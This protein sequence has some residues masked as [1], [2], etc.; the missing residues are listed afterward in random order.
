MAELALLKPG[1]KVFYY[2]GVRTFPATVVDE[3]KL[4]KVIH[5][6]RAQPAG[7][8]FGNSEFP[9]PYY[10]VKLEDGTL[11]EYVSQAVEPIGD[12]SLAGVVMVERPESVLAASAAEEDAK[13]AAA[14]A[15]AE[16]AA[17]K[18]D[19]AAKE[20]ARIAAIRADAAAQEAAAKAAEAAPKE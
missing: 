5:G 15:A 18:A 14:A 10:D 1:Q 6:V 19:L 2:D 12:V 13:K 9:G 20:E 11:V 8:S 3:S 16:E 17:A 4:P 7:R